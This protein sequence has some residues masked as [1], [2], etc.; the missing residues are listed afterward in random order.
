MIQSMFIDNG[1]G[2]FT[3][4][5]YDERRAWSQYVTVDR[6][7]PTWDRRD[8]LFASFGTDNDDATNEL[9]VALAEKAYA[10]LNESGWIGQDG[11]NSYQGIAGGWSANSMAHITGLELS[12]LRPGF[13]TPL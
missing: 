3:V 2:T 6:Y 5:F 10:Q 8:R 1:D 4:R 7:L 11:T 13:Q 9:W 12:S